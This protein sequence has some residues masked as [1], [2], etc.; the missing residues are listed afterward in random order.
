MK[1]AHLI[2]ALESLLFVSGEPLPFGRLAKILQISGDETEVCIQ[3]LSEKYASDQ[4]C[5][6]QLI[7][8]DKKAELAT[9]P[10]NTTFVEALIK[11][12]LQENLSQAALEVLAIIAYRSPI[13][14]AEIDAIRGVNCSFTLRNLLL[15][16]LIERRGNPEDSRGYIYLP[17]FRFLE[18]LGLKT[19]AALP[20]Y[21]TLSQDARLKMVS[22]ADAEETDV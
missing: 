19:I 15:R 8:K 21:A 3:K 2:S 18:S 12:A 11:S 22:E 10:E 4:L 5:G 13:A 6:L 16:D 9:K 20:D 7:V 14:R 1:S 17:T